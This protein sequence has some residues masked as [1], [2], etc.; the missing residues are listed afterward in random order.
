MKEVIYKIIY[1]RPRNH[2]GI[3]VQWGDLSQLSFGQRW[4]PWCSDIPYTVF[5]HHP[6][7]YNEKE[8][9]TV[10]YNVDDFYE[11]LL[12]A[13]EQVYKSKSPE[14][15]VEIAEGPILIETYASVSSLIFNQSHLGFNR[16]RGGI[17]F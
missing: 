14:K 12:Q 13:V 16:D 5:S 8:R 3:R 7:L 4:N 6:I 11:S 2:G 17:S 15:Q 9:E 10:T 1:S